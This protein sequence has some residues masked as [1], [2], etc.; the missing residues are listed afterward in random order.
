V[1]RFIEQR[2]ARHDP[3]LIETNITPWRRAVVG[4]LT[5]AFNFKTPNATLVPLP[6]TTGYEPP[7][8][9][10]H[11]DYSPAPP[12]NQS[13]PKQEPGLRRAR[14]VPYELHAHGDVNLSDGSVTLHFANSGKSA[15][16]FQVRAGKSADGPWTYTVGPKASLA[17]SFAVRGKEQST[18]DLAV[19]GPN[20]FFRGLEGSVNGEAIAD[21]RVK[22]VYDAEFGIT[23]EIVNAG[24]AVERLRIV[25]AYTKQSIDHSLAPGR[26]FFWHWPLLTSFGWYDL[27]ISTDSDPTFERRLAGHVETGAD[28]VSDPALGR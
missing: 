20:G 27:T 25:D 16:V 17:D 3:S 10:R 28:S 22:T 13:V 24:N 6:S 14:P 18:Y 9:V 12:A 7:D 11:D 4:D 23:L 1:I 26:L 2:F 15:A 21:L 19:Y 8:R 5:A